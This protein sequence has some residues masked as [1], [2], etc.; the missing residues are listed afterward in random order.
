MN[1]R[2][3]LFDYYNGNY[4]CS[5]FILGFFYET[6]NYLKIS[7][8]TKEYV[9]A[10]K[11]GYISNILLGI[12]ED[13]VENNNNLNYTAKKYLSELENTVETIATKT[14]DG[15]IIDNY[16]FKDAPTLVAVLRNKI[17][18][19]FYTVDLSN[20]RIIL[21]NDNVKIKININKLC[22]FILSASKNYLKRVDNNRYIKNIYLYTNKDKKPIENEED[23]K[24]IIK[25][26]KKMEF[27]LEKK[28]G[29]KIEKNMIDLFER[30]IE[31]FENTQ[32]FNLLVS[33]K[34]QLTNY[35][36]F[37]W[38][39]IS[40][41]KNADLDRLSSNIANILP[42]GLTRDQKL[43]HIYQETYRYLNT[44][45][46]KDYIMLSNIYNI[47]LID[48]AYKNSATN[49]KE[50]LTLASKG[51]KN[52]YLN[53]DEM[54]AAFISLFNVLFSY[55]MEDIYDSK[56]DYIDNTFT[57]LDYSK[58][59]FSL[60]NIEINT[61]KNKEDIL[62]NS[63]RN[64]YHKKLKEVKSMIDSRK[65]QLKQAG[66]NLK[67]KDYLM[68]TINEQELEIKNIIDNIELLNNSKGFLTNKKIVKRL[69][70]S[71]AHG[72]YE[73]KLEKNMEESLVS[74]M[75]IHEGKIVFK[76]TI[77][78]QMFFKLINDN[79]EIINQ[80]MNGEKQ[81]NNQKS[82]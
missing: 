14:E 72:N 43:F 71:I 33:L 36:N 7:K 41:N 25:R 81:K 1:K 9:N 56:K 40:E 76:G 73:I 45:F 18:H 28:N 20:S 35:Y 32:N 19:G 82:I 58:L 29:Q 68:K 22:D 55:P 31:C 24:N 17:A 74:F 26:I 49:K 13:L 50:I 21:D 61:D 27:V 77:T 38:K 23:I 2:D 52:L 48:T 80:L 44:D 4:V 42:D 8:L 70:N 62:F 39:E 30:Y 59:D 16:T 10:A 54:L 60:L 34:K 11:V 65:E 69:R 79:A 63:V 53:Y 37:D 78:L 51:Y 75:D 5:S 57:G 67:A 12:K 46:K 15:Y 66:D 6:D 47:I 3:C 64:N